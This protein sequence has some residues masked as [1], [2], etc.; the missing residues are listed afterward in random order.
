MT[1]QLSFQRHLILGR[2]WI[3]CS[4]ANLWLWMPQ[5]GRQAGVDYHRAW[6]LLKAEHVM[7]IIHYSAITVMYEAGETK[8]NINPVSYSGMHHDSFC[9][10][11]VCV[12][13]VIIMA[14]YARLL[15]VSSGLVPGCSIRDDGANFPKE[16]FEQILQPLAEIEV[17]Y[18]KSRNC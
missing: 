12:K 15:A 8:S 4:C 2:T 17:H 1:G 7:S 5:D 16:Q 14:V 3:S 6:D 9:V 10:H 18:L 11:C 13:A